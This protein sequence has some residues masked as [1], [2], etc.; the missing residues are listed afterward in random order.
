MNLHKKMNSNKLKLTS[1]KVNYK[2]FKIISVKKTPLS[3]QKFNMN[4]KI[5]SQIYNKNMK[6]K[7]VS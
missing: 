4:L 6:M 3:S 5:E 7:S 2:I 1:F